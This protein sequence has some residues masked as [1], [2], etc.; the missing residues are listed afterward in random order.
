MDTYIKIKIINEEG[1]VY[2]PIEKIR[3]P[4]YNP[5]DGAAII[6]VAMSGGRGDAGFYLEFD[7]VNTMEQTENILV[8]LNKAIA[9]APAGGGFVN[10]G[11]EFNKLAGIPEYTQVFG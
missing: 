3:L 7:G 8:E 11:G 1:F 9:S 4:F 10:L 5:A 6:K 2:I